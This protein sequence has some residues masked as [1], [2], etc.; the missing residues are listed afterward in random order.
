MYSCVWK[1]KP[2]FFASNIVRYVFSK[3][4][5]CSY[6]SP[7]FDV[8]IKTYRNVINSV[9]NFRS[10]RYNSVLQV[11]IIKFWYCDNSNYVLT[12]YYIA[13][14]VSDCDC[15]ISLYLCVINCYKKKERNRSEETKKFPLVIE[16]YKV[17]HFLNKQTHTTNITQTK[18]FIIQ[19]KFEIRTRNLLM[20]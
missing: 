3:V 11:V 20:W 19:H 2:N 18:M 15:F 8:S 13:M 5:K 10:D 12:N 6:E 7:S 1:R 4:G 9:A 17:Y 14:V 16:V